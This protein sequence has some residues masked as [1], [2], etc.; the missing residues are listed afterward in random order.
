M[1]SETGKNGGNKPSAFEDLIAKISEALSKGVVELHD[2]EIEVDEL[3]II[4]QPIV[5][6][7]IAPVTE[8][9]ERRL[10]ELAKVTF[11]E[12]KLE[13][14]GRVVE[15]RMGATKAEG[16][17]RDKSI[18]LG[19][20]NL[21]PYFYIT[22]LEPAPHFHAFGG[23]IFDMGIPLTKAVRDVFGDAL[24]NPIEWAR[25]WVNKFG[26]EAIDVHLISTDP[27]IKDTPASE[28]A[29]LIE[30]LLQ[31]VKVPIV[32]GGS[33]NPKKDVEVFKKVVDVAEG[34]RVVLNS[35]NLDMDLKDICQYL[36]KKDAVVINFAPMDLDKAREINRK[37]YDWIPRDRIML[38]LN[39]AGIGYGI[40]YGFTVN[41]RARL[42]ALIGDVE[43]QH[44]FNVGAANAWSAREAW[45]SMDPYWGP[46][47]IRGPLWET[48]TC[49]ICLLTGAD[50]FMLLHPTSMGVLKDIRDYLF[51][52]PNPSIDGALE[53]VSAKL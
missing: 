4:L 48:L 17:T 47:E 37:V 23:D 38:D 21:P 19:G 16:G 11:E 34:E 22:G 7:A 29:K 43:L 30:D 1:N 20:E 49:I 15:V 36:S 8:R 42:A 12:V 40:E 53:W 13:F 5:A 44:P 31:Q 6:K 26:A 45:I 14:P 52:E 35:L 41:E 25:V 33:G 9:I 2:V 46:R 27:T 39:I 32:V 24:D 50:Y 10:V 28:S 51:T 3:E 18:V